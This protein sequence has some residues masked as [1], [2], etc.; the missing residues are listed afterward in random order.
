M[1]DVMSLWGLDTPSNT[2]TIKVKRSCG[3]VESLPFEGVEDGDNY[4]L[5]AAEADRLQ[6]LRQTPC[7][8]CDI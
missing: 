5:P 2:V 1:N 7:L 3:H 8:T 6:G 4:R